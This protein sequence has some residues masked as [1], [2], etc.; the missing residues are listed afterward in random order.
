[1]IIVAFNLLA[2]RVHFWIDLPAGIIF[3]HYLYMWIEYFLDEFEIFFG[4]IRIFIYSL[5]GFPKKN[6]N[7]I[8]NSNNNLN[9]NNNQ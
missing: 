1:M 7:G 6:D 3:A 9:N 8:D 5:F 4:T 2:L